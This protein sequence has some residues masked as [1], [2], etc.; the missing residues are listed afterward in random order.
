MKKTTNQP[1][2][3]KS[4][5]KTGDVIKFEKT[6]TKKKTPAIHRIIHYKNFQD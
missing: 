6:K 1:V 4:T 3:F 2:D 5:L